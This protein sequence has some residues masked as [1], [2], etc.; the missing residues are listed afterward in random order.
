MS[1][2][3]NMINYHTSANALLLNKWTSIILNHESKI[4]TL[5]LN[6]N[7][8]SEIS[9]TSSNLLSTTGHIYIGMSPKLSSYAGFNGGI[10]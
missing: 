5:Y 1:T 7:Y 3:S 8:D 6:G 2:T 4:I 9:L 10:G